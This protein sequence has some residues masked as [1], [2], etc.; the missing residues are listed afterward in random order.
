MQVSGI[1][2]TGSG[3]ATGA[4]DISSLGADDVLKLVVAQLLNQDPLNPL[5]NQEFVL[6]MAQLTTLEQSRAMANAVTSLADAARLGSAASLIDRTVMYREPVT[7][8]VLTGTVTQVQADA[9]AIQVIIDGQPVPLENL[10]QIG[11][12]AAPLSTETQT[13]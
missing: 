2:P 7:G 3:A 13:P 6:Q 5:S 11:S 4:S 1:T 12:M 10:V 8:N 9:I